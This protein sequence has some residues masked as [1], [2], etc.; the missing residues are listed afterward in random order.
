[1]VTVAEV[2]EK[3]AEEMEDG[4]EVVIRKYMSEYRFDVAH[5]DDAEGF[6][7]SDVY[8]YSFYPARNADECGQLFIELAGEWNGGRR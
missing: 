5:D 3:F 6:M 7:D 2:C 1:M 4:I 8:S